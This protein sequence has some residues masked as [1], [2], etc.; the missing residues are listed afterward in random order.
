MRNS[1]KY[2]II[3]F[4]FLL[5]ANTTL[6]AQSTNKLLRQGNKEYKEQKYNNATESYTKA[7]QQA[8]KEVRGYFNLGD[9]YFMMNQL[10]KAKEMYQQS[11]TLSTNAEIKA[12]AFYNIGNAHY[13]QEKWQESVNAYKQSLKYNPKDKDAKYN[14]MMAM[15]K[16]KKDKNGGGGKNNQDK[17]DNNQDKDNKN[18][19]KNQ[20]Q[21]NQNNQQQNKQQQNQGNNEEQKNQQ[22]QNASQMGDKQAEQML[23][24]IA[25]DEAKTQEKVNKQ[26]AKPVKGKIQKDW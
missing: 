8:P 2:I 18:Q 5:T 1:L 6:F 7:L 22:Q 10:D 20:Q 9:T 12:K 11:A 3:T 23:D 15:A 21:Q 25:A 17:K 26:K 24:A 19:D 16:I 4:F 13:K 14:L